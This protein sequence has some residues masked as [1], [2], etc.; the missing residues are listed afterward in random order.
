MSL[1]TRL[2]VFPC[3]N[4][5]SFSLL[6]KGTAAAAGIAEGEDTRPRCWLNYIYIVMGSFPSTF[7][8]LS[9]HFAELFSGRS[10]LSWVRCVLPVLTLA[11]ED[12]KMAW[13]RGREMP[14][15]WRLI[16][17]T[18]FLYSWMEHSHGCLHVYLAF[19]ALRHHLCS[20]LIIS[21]VPIFVIM[22]VIQ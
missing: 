6:T 3:F 5:S 13:W 12:G 17:N 10:V 19:T 7:G 16:Y 22:F 11:G 15:R 4:D 21:L 20:G 8:L 18:S 2:Y 14:H 1:W 9:S